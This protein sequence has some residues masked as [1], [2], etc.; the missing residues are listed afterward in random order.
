MIFNLF[1]VEF[2]SHYLEV[3]FIRISKGIR[4]Y[5]LFG[6]FY[7]HGTIIITVFFKEIVLKWDQ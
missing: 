4:D 6:F 3:S 2:S 7:N 5:D 1:R